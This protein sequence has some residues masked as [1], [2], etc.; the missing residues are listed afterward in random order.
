MKAFAI[1]FGLASGLALASPVVERD[2]KTLET[3][4][5]AAILCGGLCAP[6]IE[7]PPAYA[8]CVAACLATGNDG[9]VVFDV[10]DF[11][12]KYKE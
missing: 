10:R 1:L 3:R 7:T 8:A 9:G 6:L 5:Y 11:M 12:E 4:G 2:G